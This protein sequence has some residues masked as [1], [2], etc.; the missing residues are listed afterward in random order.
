VRC[1]VVRQLHYSTESN[2]SIDVVLFLNGIP[3]ATIELKTEF[4]Q[5]VGTAVGQY[6]NDRKP[7]NPKT[8]HRER[9]LTE[10]VGA[11]VHFAVSDEEVY[12]TTK[13]D[14]DESV[15]LPFNRGDDDGA[16]N[17]PNPN[18]A[19]TAYLWESVLERSSFLDILHKFAHIEK[20]VTTRESGGLLRT[21]NWYSRVIINWTWFAS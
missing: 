21:S 5:T 10:K 7:I 9:L 6:K 14:G 20:K 2:N 13:L 15:F 16:G 11:I 8:G 1:R 18:G 4:T 19:K 3:I 17:P 12:M